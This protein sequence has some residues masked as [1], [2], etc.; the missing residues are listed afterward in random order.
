MSFLKKTGGAPPFHRPYLPDVL[1]YLQVSTCLS[2]VCLFKLPHC[3][4]LKANPVYFTGEGIGNSNHGCSF[5]QYENTLLSVL[6]V[7]ANAT[8]MGISSEIMFQL[9]P[10]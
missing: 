1:V 5:F 7:G 8:S 10:I 3:I 6:T 2:S 4:G 9:Y